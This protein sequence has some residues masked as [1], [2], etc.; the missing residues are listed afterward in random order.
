MQRE[1]SQEGEFGA[2]AAGQPE[3]LVIDLRA[4]TRITG[5][6]TQTTSKKP[7]PAPGP[8]HHRIPGH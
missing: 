1:G 5:R 7:S 4:T 2:A 8:F 3:G 6:L